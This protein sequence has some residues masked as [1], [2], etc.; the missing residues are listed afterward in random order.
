MYRLCEL[1]VL[2][3]SLN[4]WVKAFSLARRIL[5]EGLPPEG[6]QL[7]GRK[8]FQNLHRTH[9]DTRLLLPMAGKLCR[10]FYTVDTFF[11]RPPF[12]LRA[13]LVHIRC[14]P[15]HTVHKPPS[16]PFHI[17]QL[18]TYILCMLRCTPPLYLTTKE[19]R[20]ERFMK[21]RYSLLC[22]RRLVA[23]DQSNTTH[24]PIRG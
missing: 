1:T 20:R 2:L 13:S 11:P 5:L 8:P 7:E 3:W 21:R 22:G 19:G 14:C 12:C 16:R 24:P 6:P 10:L 4:A 17:S 15:L 9:R 23:S 18:Q